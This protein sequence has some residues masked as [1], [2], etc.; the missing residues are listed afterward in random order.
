MQRDLRALSLKR[1]NDVCLEKWL[2][3]D[4]SEP[5]EHRPFARYKSTDIP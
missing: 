3:T 1:F 4:S 5:S 2:V